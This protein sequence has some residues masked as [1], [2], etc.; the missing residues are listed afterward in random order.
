MAV[1]PENPRRFLRSTEW[2]KAT[3]GCFL[4]Q[5]GRRAAWLLVIVGGTVP[6]AAAA[7]TPSDAVSPNRAARLQAAAAVPLDRLPA[8]EQRACEQCL[9]A[10]TL[11]RRLPPATVSCDGGFLEFVLERPEV[12]VDVW[13]VLGIS[14]LSI[15]PT[16][17]GRW[18]LAD[19]YGTVGSVRLVHR[20]R[21]ADGGLFVYLGRGGYSGPLAPH[22]LTG[23]CVVI[24]RHAPAGVDAAG[25]ERHEV[26]IDA[27]LDVDGL[28]LELVT[29]AL[30]PLIVHSAA[31]NLREIALFISQFAAAAERNPAAI[32]RLASRMTRTSPEDRRTLV[33]LASGIDAE[34]AGDATEDVQAT[35]AA[36]WLPVEP[37]D[38]P[39]RR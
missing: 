16:G 31:A 15:D 36:R 5:I 23:S 38:A 30:Q 11:H 28:G 14:R 20:E 33:A 35:L 9:A 12:L 2:K 24:V 21:R 34:P 27:F 19:G 4:G 39:R 3:E 18:R 22:D 8:S 25:R 17:P 37:A 1:D 26:R 32:A 13:R 10:S 29:R 7:P 6:H